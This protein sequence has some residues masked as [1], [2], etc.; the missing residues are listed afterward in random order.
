M[1]AL[2]CGRTGVISLMLDDA[3]TDYVYGFLPERSFRMPTAPPRAV[4]VS[5]GLHDLASGDSAGD[6]WA[7]VTHWMV[8]KV[9]RL[10]AADPPGHV[11]VAATTVA[12]SADKPVTLTCPPGT[13]VTG[14]GGYL[15]APSTDV[16][17]PAAKVPNPDMPTAPRSQ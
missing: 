17:G 10:A 14:G 9:A 6:S 5:A 15:T 12:S 1:M 8:S 3:R 16:R 2:Q 4:N 7:T 11:R 13:V